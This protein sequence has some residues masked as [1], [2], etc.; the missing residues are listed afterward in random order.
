IDKKRNGPKIW[1]YRTPN[2]ESKGEATVTY[3]DPYTANSAIDWFN[4]KEFDKNIIK[5]QLATRKS[6][7]GGFRGGR[8]SRG[9]GF[10]GGDRGRGGDRDG[11]RGGRG[12]MGRGGGGPGG[13]RREGDWECQNDTDKGPCGNVNFG[14]RQN[15]NRCQAPKP[16]GG[17]SGGMGMD[18]GRSGYS[19][20]GGDRGDERGTR[21]LRWTRWRQRWRQGWFHGPWWPRRWTHEGYGS[22]K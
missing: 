13:P 2:G 21:L 16:G 18:R 11:G 17:D 15:C 9:G 1:I 20:R 5:V 10:R 6:P 12:G 7:F 4:G 3:D 22:Q 19:G 14:W 8:G